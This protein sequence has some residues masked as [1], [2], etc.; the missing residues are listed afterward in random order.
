MKYIVITDKVLADLI[1]EVNFK[2][3]SGYICQGGIMKCEDYKMY[4]QAMIEKS[5]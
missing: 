5:N 3:D 1:D 2:L 4:Y